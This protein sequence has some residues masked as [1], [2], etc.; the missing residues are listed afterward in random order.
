[1]S[2][3]GDIL[4]N[5]GDDVGRLSDEEFDVRFLA[6]YE[7][8]EELTE[9]CRLALQ[10]MSDE[11]YLGRVSSA[12]TMGRAMGLLRD[13]YDLNAPPGWYPAMKRLRDDANKFKTT[14][15]H[16]LSL[17]D[18]ERAFQSRREQSRLPTAEELELMRAEM[19]IL[20]EAI[21]RWEQIGTSKEQCL[22]DKCKETVADLNPGL[23][24]A[25]R[26]I[27]SVVSEASEMGSPRPAWAIQF[28]DDLL[29]RRDRL[30]E[31][32]R[33]HGGAL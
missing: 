3:I 19:A 6:H 2:T 20:D 21:K 22:Q 13:K 14:T 27:R 24:A 10:E 8:K 29:K 7:Y 32:F 12:R 16:S 30:M 23:A 26:F 25:L 9:C 5:S 17:E 18:A 15:E 31:L 1:M 11:T 4:G 28:R 33:L